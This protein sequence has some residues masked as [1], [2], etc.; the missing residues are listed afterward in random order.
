MAQIT[1]FEAL[2]AFA[3]QVA[4]APRAWRNFSTAIGE[5]LETAEAAFAHAPDCRRRIID[6]SSDGTSNEGPAPYMRHT[7]LQAQGITVNALV[8]EEPGG[9]DL[10]G[11]FWEQV[12]TGEGAF[13]VT[14]NGYADYPAR[15]REKLLR[16][17]ARAVTQNTRN[18]RYIAQLRQ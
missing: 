12:I 15:I 18:L 11:Y 7:S 10:T 3:A 1:S 2:D 14:A 4:T 6:I 8:I 16:E 5:A 17:A 9:E 13:V